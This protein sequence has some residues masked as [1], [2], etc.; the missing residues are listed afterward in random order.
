MI[1]S[2]IDLATFRF[3]VQCLNHCSTADLTISTQWKL[4]A[5]VCAELAFLS[6]T[7]KAYF[8]CCDICCNCER[9]KT[10]T[11]AKMLSSFEFLLVE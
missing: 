9:T 8:I 10:E 7:K 3:A 2:G 11:S 4:V 6:L 1:P 5:V